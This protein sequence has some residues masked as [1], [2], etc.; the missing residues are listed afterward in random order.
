MEPEEQA[1]AVLRKSPQ[2]Q[3][4]IRPMNVYNWFDETPEQEKVFEDWTVREV[5]IAE[6]RPIEEIRSIMGLPPPGPDA[7]E[8]ILE[9]FERLPPRHLS[10]PNYKKPSE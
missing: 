1:A 7:P 8:C 9:I 6:G 3:E 4:Y 10:D 2:D 5:A